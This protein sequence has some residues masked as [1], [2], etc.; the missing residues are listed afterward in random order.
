MAAFDEVLRA[1]RCGEVYNVGG[2]RRSNCSMLEAIALCERVAG[3]SLEWSL[4]ESNRAGD[5]IWYITDMA[6]F[7]A[8]YPGWQQRR[9]LTGML[10]EMYEKNVERWLAE[11]NLTSAR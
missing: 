10:R 4:A 6:K 8:H 9:D 7:K 3:R 11:R 2:T 1:P 5:H